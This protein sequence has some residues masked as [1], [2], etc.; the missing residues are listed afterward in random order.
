M[1]TCRIKIK[2]EMH[3]SFTYSYTCILNVYFRGT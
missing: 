3:I 2:I 1:Y